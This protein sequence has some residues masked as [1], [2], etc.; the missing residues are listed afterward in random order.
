MRKLLLLALALSIALLCIVMQRAAQAEDYAEADMSSE[1]A[2]PRLTGTI[3]VLRDAA[4]QEPN[5]VTDVVLLFAL[6]LN[7]VADVPFEY[8]VRVYLAAQEFSLDPYDLAATLISEHSG[9]DYDFSV[10]NSAGYRYEFD[11]ETTSLGRHTKKGEKERGLFQVKPN[12]VHVANGKLGTAWT[13]DDLFDPAINIRIGA[14]VVSENMASHEGCPSKARDRG[15]TDTLHSWTAHFKCGR[16]ARDDLR[17]RCRTAQRKWDKLRGSLTSLLP[18][19]AKRFGKVHNDR[20]RKIIEAYQ[21]KSKHLLRRRIRRICEK[22]EIEVPKRLKKMSVE[23][24]QEELRWLSDA[25]GEAG[26]S[27]D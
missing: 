24:L 17:G 27:G 2:W 22:H 14:F 1:I 21:S 7:V 16:S 19:S 15:L 6:H 25:T 20:L 4:E 5:P 11:Y 23:Q 10:Y 13:K 12:W 3:S 26:M 9:P 8:G 18:G